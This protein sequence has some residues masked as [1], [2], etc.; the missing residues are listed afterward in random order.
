MSRSDYSF[1]SRMKNFAA[2]AL[3]I[4]SLSRCLLVCS[5]SL[6]TMS[7]SA[8]A[9]EQSLPVNKTTWV[10][11]D[12]AVKDYQQLLGDLPTDAEL[13][14]LQADRDGFSQIA[15]ELY[16]QHNIAQIHLISHGRDGEIQAG[17]IWLSADSI[18]NARNHL[19]FIGEA[20]A[21]NGSIYIY[22]CQVAAGVKGKALLNNIASITNASVAASDDWT[23]D[24]KQGGNWQLETG[25]C[26]R[27]SSGQYS[28]NQ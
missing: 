5:F 11:V 18:D 28:A 3:N 27:H 15:E 21:T 2:T 6:V 10:F 4:N 22:G 9:A 25:N 12:P 16:G 19:A 23:G 13:R 14:I 17:N 8:Q 24:A 20:L 1:C 7:F 26:Y